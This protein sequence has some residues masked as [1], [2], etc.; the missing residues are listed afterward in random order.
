MLAL[1]G[2]HQAGAGDK[3]LRGALRLAAYAERS[4]AAPGFT[5]G[6]FGGEPKPQA[7][8][9]KSTEHNIDLAAA[10]ARLADA[11]HDPHW[12]MRAAQASAWSPRCGM[13]V[14]SPPAPGLDGR[15]PNRFLAL[16]AQLWP[17][18]A[19]PGGV[20]RYGA[21]L[22]TARAKMWAGDGFTY[23]E[24]GKA[25]WTKAPPRPPAGGADG[26]VRAG[27]AAA[28]GGRARPARPTAA[29]S[30]PTAIPIPASVW[31]PTPPRRGAISIS[32]IWV[33]WPGRRWRSAASIPSP[34]KRHCLKARAV[35]H[36][37]HIVMEISMRL[38]A[39]VLAGL[40]LATPAFAVETFPAGFKTQTVKTNGTEI[41]VRSGG[42]GPA[43]GAAARL[44][45]QR[46]HV[47]AGGQGADGDAYGDRT[48]PA[49]LRP[50]RPILMAATPRRTRRWTSPG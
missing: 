26:P 45:R 42:A 34:E 18:L 11:T 21:A 15:T 43:V 4:F 9:W 6:T 37:V 10:F 17:L 38:A 20:A 1:L 44:R 41:H 16:D 49:R 24:T 40:L 47:G 46:R 48:R 25:V 29:I 7:N 12:A 28:G 36:S 19:L 32:R 23:S 13:G 50:L 31:T 5:G 8:S 14:L 33:P 39:A 30:P 27:G 3:Y 22:K 2:L 35:E